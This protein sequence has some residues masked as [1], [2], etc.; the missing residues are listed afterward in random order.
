MKHVNEEIKLN[1]VTIVKAILQIIIFVLSHARGFR[2]EKK[3]EICVLL[4]RKYSQLMDIQSLDH[5]F[6]D[7]TQNAYKFLK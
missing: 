4:Y 6:Q 1:F 2:L 3:E 7:F 5:I